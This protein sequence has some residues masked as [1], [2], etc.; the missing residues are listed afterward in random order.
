MEVNMSWTAFKA[1]LN[2]KNVNVQ[3]F[4]ANNAYY[5]YLTNGTMTLS[6]IILTDGSQAADQAD[7]EANYKA[8]GNNAITKIL[9]SPSSPTFATVGTSS[10]QILPSTPFRRGLILTNTSK[11]RISIGL[12][13]AAVLN[14]GITL[15]PSGVWV[16]DAF[17]SIITAVFAIADKS[18][19][20]LAI[21]ELV[22]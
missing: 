11:N 16:M 9:A 8:V 18:G 13:A 3:W 17:N 6:C 12:G 19:S 5:L 7:F 20:N 2:S 1:N 22:I 15:D 21:Q 10:G 4:V 14:S